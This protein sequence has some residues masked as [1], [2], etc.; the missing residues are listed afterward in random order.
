MRNLTILAAD[1]LVWQ[2]QAAQKMVR[3]LLRI[4]G[5]FRGLPAQRATSFEG[6]APRAT[7]LQC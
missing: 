7:A 1:T 2:T 3:G 4:S 6:R 5:A